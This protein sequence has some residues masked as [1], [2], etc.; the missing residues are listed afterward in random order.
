M[1]SLFALVVGASL[2]AN[3]HDT[4]KNAMEAA[5]QKAKAAD[6]AGAVQDADEA[7]RLSGANAVERINAVLFKADLAQ[8]QKDF[9]KAK[10]EYDKVISD[11]QASLQQ[12]L[13]AIT[14]KVAILRTEKK[15]EEAKAVYLAALEGPHFQLP[16]GKEEILFAIARQYETDRHFAKAA[17]FYE[18][19]SNSQQASRPQRILALKS[20]GKALIEQT[21][22]EEARTQYAKILAFA[23]LTPAEKSAALID[24]ASSFEAEGEFQKAKDEYVKASQV[25]RIAPATRKQALA[26]LATFHKNRNDLNAFK[27]T[28]AAIRDVDGSVDAAVLRNYALL[29]NSA[30]NPEEEEKAWSEIIAIPGLQGRALVEPVS[31]KINLLAARKDIEGIKQ[32]ASGLSGRTLTDE[33]KAFL[34]LLMAGWTAPNGDLAKFEAPSLNPLNAEKQ[35]TAYIDAGKVMMHL[36]N[37]DAARFFA[38]KAESIFKQSVSPVYDCQLVNQAPRGVDAWQNS[39]IVKDAS[40]REDR[41]EEYNK[42]ASE[43]LINDVNVVRTVVTDGAQKK[44]PVGFYMATDSRGWH[45]YLQYKDDQAEQVLAG[46]VSGGELEMYMA[47]GMGECYYQFTIGVP[48]GKPSF[49][50]WSSPYKNYRKL[51]HYLVSEVAPIDGGFGIY[52]CFP[53]ELMYDKLP[54]DG[55]LWPFG[56]VNFGRA[57]GFTWG[58]GQVHELNR[59]GRVKFSGIEKALPAIHR[60]IAMK[61]YANYKKTA[62]NAKVIWS[63]REKGDRAFFE[64]VLQP[65]INKLD[66]LGKLVT[67][68]MTESDSEMLFRQ[69]VPTWMEFDYRIAELRTRYLTDK[70]IAP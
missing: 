21:K 11:A 9:S 70:L 50:A 36:R 53:W 49:V 7:I 35:A 24:I 27:Q 60:W 3:A 56:V 28:L 23:D 10:D 44:A 66:E 52:L 55:D 58:S 51:D 42:K 46:L 14:K 25:E 37:Y 34:T 39:S 6:F 30:A 62:A 45:V 64:T 48:A 1:G 26:A 15:F 41:F 54:K 38:Q 18:K 32:F 33:Q 19:A 40:R 17:E 16:G 67:S 22:F 12:K 2:N 29:A 47:P 57:G 31:K 69:A 13:A 20:L 4:A 59:F 65:E 5:R 8:S 68:Q 43:L 61:A 63:D